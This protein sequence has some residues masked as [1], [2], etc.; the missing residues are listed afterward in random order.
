MGVFSFAVTAA[1]WMVDG[2]TAKSAGAFWTM[3]T[4]GAVCAFV[5][6]GAELF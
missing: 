2:F 5:P 1:A 3:M 6:T 4:C